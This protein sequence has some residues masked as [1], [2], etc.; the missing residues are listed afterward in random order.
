MIIWR[1][2]KM[3]VPQVIHFNGIF[4]CKLSIWGYHVR[5]PPYTHDL[6]L[7]FR[8]ACGL[9]SLG[10][11]QLW[12]CRQ[13]A[14][15]PVTSTV[16]RWSVQLSNSQGVLIMWNMSEITA[17]FCFGN[18]CLDAPTCQFMSEPRDM[19][20]DWLKNTAH[21]IWNTSGNM[22]RMHL[23]HHYSRLWSRIIYRTIQNHLESSRII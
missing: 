17:M 19:V 8:S 5:N 14:R 12:R 3:V 18:I 10:S 4:N 9:L 11:R 6:I 16:L 15:L 2:P 20:Q 21:I 13:P 7:R 1:F 23:I 22:S